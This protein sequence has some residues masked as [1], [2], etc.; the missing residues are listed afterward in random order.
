[1]A[2]LARRQH[3]I[4]ARAQLLT[5]GLGR[6]AIELRVANGRLH[7]VH[8]GVYAVGHEVV[9]R[10]GR[11]MAA[12]LGGGPGAVLSHASAAA[13]LG[14]RPSDAV[15]TDI[16]TDRRL[17]SR[18]GLRFHYCVLPADEVTVADGIPVT[19]PARTLFDLA[20]VVPLAQLQRAGKEAEVKRLWGQLSLPDLLERHPGRPGAGAIRAV[21]ETPDRGVTRNDVEEALAAL[22]RRARLPHPLFNTPLKLGSRFMEPDCMWPEQRVIVE[23]DGYETHGTRDSFESDRARD[24]ALTAA[25]WLVIRVTWRQL[26]DEPAQ[27][28]RDLRTVLRRRSAPRPRQAARAARRPWGRGRAP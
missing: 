28:A 5:I 18:P 10:E 21:I 2:G 20:G 13:H 15:T 3:G 8:R 16:T 14:I 26:R 6:R 22:V 25:G 4:V 27:I 12:V 19:T 11:W 17:R 24:R 1:V 23:V 7:L 9:S